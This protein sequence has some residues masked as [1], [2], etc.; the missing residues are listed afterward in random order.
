MKSPPAVLAVDQLN[1]Q[2]QDLM[3]YLDQVEWRVMYVSLSQKIPDHFLYS[4]VCLLK[5]P[6]VRSLFAFSSKCFRSVSLFVRVMALSFLLQEAVLHPSYFLTA[7]TMIVEYTRTS[8]S[9]S[10]NGTSQNRCCE[11]YRFICG[12]HITIGNT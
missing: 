3:H 7:Q 5:Q 11:F 1:E 9:M 8:A 12:G 2:L 10:S 4:T 6:F